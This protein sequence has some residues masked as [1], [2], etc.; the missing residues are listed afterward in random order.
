VCGLPHRGVAYA[1][2]RPDGP[3]NDLTRV[4]ADPDLNR[5]ALGATYL[6][7]VSLDSLLHPQGGVTAADGVIFLREGRAEERHD[8]VSHHLVHHALVAVDGFHHPF[9]H[10]IEEFARFLW[11][12]VRKQLHR[13]FQVGEE[14]GDLLALALQRAL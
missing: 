10:G 6:L 7:S 13:T 11:V 5:D 12:A 1:Q 2:V 4:K 9:Q 8:P 3:H 14:H